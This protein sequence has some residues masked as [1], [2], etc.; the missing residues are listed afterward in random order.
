MIPSF[1][2]F[3]AFIF[4]IVI[5]SVFFAVCRGFFKSFLSF[6]G[7]VLALFIGLE[8]GSIFAPV[9]DSIAVSK[10][11]SSVIGAFLIFVIFAVLF[12]FVNNIVIKH[13]EDHLGGLLDRSFG[14]VFGFFRGCFIVS[15]VF[16]VMTMMIDTL[17]VEDEDKFKDPESNVPAWTKKSEVVVLLKRGA[18]LIAMF[19]P[20][21]FEQELHKTI[22]ESTNEEGQ[23]ELPS[24]RAEKIR[25]INKV[26][27]S[28]PQEVIDKVNDSDLITL[29]DMSAQPELKAQI[30]EEIAQKYYEYNQAK[31][32][33]SEDHKA[34]ADNNSKYHKI[35]M[36]LENE[37]WRFRMAAKQAVKESD[38]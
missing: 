24:T 19:I 13:M 25:S 28:L 27:N 17:N 35:M 18:D 16:Y 37:I 26:L 38:R 7:W 33:D 1:S 6:I 9:F 2:S 23:V 14:L 36:M 11:M 22:M 21:D 30:L 32:L 34:I 29:Q 20:R 3:D 5:F 8:M 12:A 15:I 31:M 4:G 10:S